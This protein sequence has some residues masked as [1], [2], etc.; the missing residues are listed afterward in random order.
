VR[1]FAAR[2]IHSN[3]RSFVLIHFVRRTILVIMRRFFRSFGAGVPGASLVLPS[4]A[5]G[6]AM[7]LLFLYDGSA[8]K[9]VGRRDG[10]KTSTPAYSK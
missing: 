2:E 6:S 10:T 4:L 7:V 8:T 1:D 9:F 5:L 3:E